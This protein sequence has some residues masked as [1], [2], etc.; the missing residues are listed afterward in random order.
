MKKRIAIILHG[1]SPNGVET[2]FAE[3]SALW[4]R[5]KYELYYFLAVDPGTEQYYEDLVVRNGCRVIHLHDLNGA[6]KL[7]WART[8][9]KTLAEYGPFDAVHSNLS[10]LSG[11]N[12]RIARKEGIPVRIAHVHTFPRE[13]D[14]VAH[15]LYRFGMRPLIARNAT[16]R[17]ACSPE[18][19]KEAYGKSSFQVIENGIMLKD[20]LAVGEQKPDRDGKQEPLRFITVGRISE[21]KNPGFLLEVFCSVHQ[22][23]PE[24]SLIWVGDGPLRRPIEKKTVDLGL[25][26]AVF[27]TGIRENV[28]EL[29]AQCDYFLFPS[30]HE[31]FG[32]ALVEAQAAG[33]DC[34]ASDAVP[35]STDCGKVRFLSLGQTAGE[36]AEEIA[37]HIDSG[38]HMQLDRKRIEHFDISR[39]AQRL[40]QL[41]DQ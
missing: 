9:R 4:D 18:A 28:P 14:S 16:D 6:R 26:D 37:A 38:K 22:M 35:K 10:L 33:L 1:L 3:L 12:L 29:L 17:L 34:F 2:M 8:L 7:Q 25:Q 21:D 20:F 36:W 32:N 41:Y 31:G 15:C 5:E 13:S 24:A 19:G 23:I 40:M 11:L 39:M 30:L 27:F